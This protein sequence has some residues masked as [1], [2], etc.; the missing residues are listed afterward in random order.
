M[1]KSLVLVGC[2]LAL[3][4]V[5]A[6]GSSDSDS[7]GTGGA[8]GTAGGG[9]G[10]TSGAS[11]V[12]GNQDGWWCSCDGISS[13]GLPATYTQE[14]AEA[15][16]ADA[17][18]DAGGTPTVEPKLNVIGTPECDAFC[19]KA[20]ALGCPG[21]TCAERADF[22]C[23]VSANSCPAAELASLECETQNGTFSCDADSWKMSAQG[24]GTFSELCP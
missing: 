24:C 20:D 10:G 5:S 6:C 23:Q 15:A 7:S 8:A 1:R 21:D 16:C 2:A 11:G 22:W 14:Q 3:G 9:S 18:G 4:L 12:G 19:A 17:C 13:V